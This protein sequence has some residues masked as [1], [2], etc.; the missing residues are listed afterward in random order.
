M[1]STHFP[2]YFLAVMPIYFLIT[3]FDLSFVYAQPVLGPQSPFA[4]DRVLVAF[5]PGTAATDVAA[6]HRQARGRVVRTIGAIG[7]QVVSVPSGTVLEA[8]GH[9]QRNPNVKFAEPNYRRPLFLPKTSEGSI[10]SLNI[11]NSF[12]EQWGLHNTGQTFGA[13][14]DPVTLELIPAAY[15]GVADADIDAQ[16]AWNI[17]HG[18]SSVHIAILDTGIS[19]EHADL[20]TK[21]LPPVNFVADKGSSLDDIVGHGTHV[22][23]IAAAETD[24]GVGIAGVAW[25]AM[26]GSLK[27]CYED[28][29]LAVFGI[30]QA[31]CEDADIA[32]AIVHA[33]DHGYHVINMSLAG[34]QFSQTL[35]DAVTYASATG[36]VIVAGA[37]NDY[38]IAKRY[39]AAYDEVIAVAATDYFDNLAYFSTFSLDSDDWVSV[40]A[41]GHTVL[42][43]VPGQLCDLAPD[44]PGGCYDWKSGTSMAAPHV[45]GM[46]ALLWGYNPELTHTEIRNAIENSADTVGALGQ[47]ILSWTAHGRVNLHQALLSV[48]AGSGSGGGSGGGGSG[49][50]GSGEDTVPPVISNVGSAEANGQNFT[51]TWDTDEAANSVVNFP[52]CG[53]FTN[54]ALVTSH[55]MGFRGRN[56]TAY[57]YFVESTDAAG[58]KATSGPHVHQN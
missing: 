43:T 57:E 37:G 48:P 47:N 36:L 27:V 4:S 30:I 18:S 8:L 45:A 24:N 52:C 13:I 21:C 40:A 41:P 19:C 17:S 56:G 5:Q 50:G 3:L 2:H 49:G 10:P 33:A 12:T 51:I 9:Y 38:G 29:S 6:A 39:P 55:S 7:V 32:A 46:A 44:D 58:N 22:A 54:D 25:D 34:P 42:S 53:T 1:K 31:F 11:A 23:G 14:V 20:D 26:V 35:Q 16:E 28:M 15:V